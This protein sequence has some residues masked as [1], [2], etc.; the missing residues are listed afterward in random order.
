MQGYVTQYVHWLHSGAVNQGSGEKKTYAS[1]NIILTI[2]G[3]RAM[4]LNMSIGYIVG[5]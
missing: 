3:S 2:G 5:L 4:A 1:L